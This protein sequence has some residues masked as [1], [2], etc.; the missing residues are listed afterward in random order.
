MFQ[1]LEKETTITLQPIR[2]NWHYVLW[3]RNVTVMI[4][5]LLIPLIL[6]AYWNFNTFSVI[7]RRQRLQNRPSLC[8]VV[9]ECIR[10]GLLDTGNRT[11]SYDSVVP[12]S[13]FEELNTGQVTS[14]ARR[15]SRSEQSKIY[16][17][18]SF[19]CKCNIIGR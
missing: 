5:S 15:G 16:F 3:Y 13:V 4:V 11:H 9:P 17:Y 1:V 14:N 7:L 2:L 6:L 8:P 12:R 10:D 18:Q 19:I